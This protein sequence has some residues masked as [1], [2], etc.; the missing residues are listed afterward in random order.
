MGTKLR[1]SLSADEAE[2]AVVREVA[3]GC[4]GQFRARGTAKPFAPAWVDLRVGSGV[5]G[6]WRDG[7]VPQRQHGFDRP[8]GT[9]GPRVN[10]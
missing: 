4:P 10:D 6:D 2:A 8:D 1:W 3:A 5:G 7:V 9:G